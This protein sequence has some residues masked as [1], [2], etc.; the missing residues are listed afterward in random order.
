[1]CHPG[2]TVCA[3][4]P[5]KICVPSGSAVP[6]ER[7][8]I[9]LSRGSNARGSVVGACV[10]NSRITPSVSR[11]DFAGRLKKVVAVEANTAGCKGT[12]IDRSTE[13]TTTVR[14]ITT[15][16]VEAFRTKLA[17]L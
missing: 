5:R 7:D 16:A 10:C 14:Y 8:T 11:T 6:L 12:A 13:T 1:M 9:R 15:R 3:W 17:R 2:I 4:C